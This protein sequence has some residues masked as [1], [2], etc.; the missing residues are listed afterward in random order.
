MISCICA[1]RSEPVIRE[2]IRKGFDT[3]E[4]LQDELGVCLAC[5]LCYPYIID[6]I[7]EEGGSV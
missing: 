3:I 4:K 7:K 2:H 6:M 1:N 5:N